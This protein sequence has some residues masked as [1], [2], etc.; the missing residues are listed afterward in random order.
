MSITETVALP[1]LAT[2]KRLPSWLRANA[3]GKA[4]TR[5]SVDDEVGLA[6]MRWPVVVSITETVPLP[7]LATY[8][9]PSGPITAAE[10]FTPTG[11]EGLVTNFGAAEAANVASVPVLW[12]FSDEPYGLGREPRAN[13]AMPNGE[14]AGATGPSGASGVNPVVANAANTTLLT[15]P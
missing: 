2:Y 1:L 4:P 11:I 12:L 5:M 14:L 15:S 8:M 13:S 9:R 7:V 3:L 6:S 10:G